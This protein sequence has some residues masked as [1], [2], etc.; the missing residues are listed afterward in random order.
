M[1][2]CEQCRDPHTINW[3]E[4][5]SGTPNILNFHGTGAFDIVRFESWDSFLLEMV[6]REKDSVTVSVRRRGAGTGGW[7]KNNPYLKVRELD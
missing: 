1:F 6:A 2:I 7:S 5:F 3:I 4:E